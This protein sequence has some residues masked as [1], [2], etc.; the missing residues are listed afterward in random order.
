MLVILYSLA[1]H[2]PIL[3]PQ[4]TALWFQVGFTQLTAPARQQPVEW[5]TDW[6]IFDLWLLLFL[7]QVLAEV[8]SV[9][10]Q[11]WWGFPLSSGSSPQWTNSSVSFSLFLRLKGVMTSHCYWSL[12]AYKSASILM[13]GSFSHITK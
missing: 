13:C 11:L 7:F 5:Q 6:S 8:A 10:Q 1:F 4:G 9:C 3:C 2:C 12:G